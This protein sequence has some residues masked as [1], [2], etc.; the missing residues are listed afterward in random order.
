LETACNQPILPHAIIILNASQNDI[1]PKLWEVDFATKSLLDSLSA[2]V[3]QN[4]TFAQYAKFWRERGRV[5]ENVEELMTCYYS[6]VRVRI[7]RYL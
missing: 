4:A 1:D 3:N 7:H 5:I 6:S 2:T